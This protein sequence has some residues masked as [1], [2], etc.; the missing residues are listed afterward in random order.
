MPMPVVCVAVAGQASPHSRGKQ[1]GNQGGGQNPLLDG[2]RDRLPAVLGSELLID[3]LEVIVHGVGRDAQSIRDLFVLETL[4][5]QLEDIEF[6]VGEGVGIDSV[7]CGRRHGAWDLRALD[8]RRRFSV[9]ERL[10][11]APDESVRLVASSDS[12][13][14]IG[15]DRTRLD[16]RPDKAP[17]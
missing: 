6:A 15:H 9:L 1:G 3:V 17:G 13:E 5:E 10:Q 8:R 11:H 14:H 12:L 16:E 7:S 4:P 2:A